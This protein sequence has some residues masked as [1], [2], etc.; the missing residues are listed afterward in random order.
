MLPHPRP[1]C[2]ARRLPGWGGT[3]GVGGP[4]RISRLRVLRARPIYPAIGIGG[5][6]VLRARPIPR[7]KRLRDLPP[8]D[9]LRISL[10]SALRARPG[11]RS[12]RRSQGAPA[13][14]GHTAGHIPHLAV[15]GVPARI[16]LRR[17]AAHGARSAK[18]TVTMQ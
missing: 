10:P 8:R 1:H 17:P 18:L 5:G 11:D 15:H 14:G 7:G 9:W 12:R 16:S 6:R 3:E 2:A 4:W 13:P